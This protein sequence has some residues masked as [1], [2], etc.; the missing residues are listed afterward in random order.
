MNKKI[1][2]SIQSYTNNV[3][4]PGHPLFLVQS[5]RQSACQLSP[6]PPPLQKILATVTSFNHSKATTTS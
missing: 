4:R 5:V 3:R 6:Q 2:G 1:K